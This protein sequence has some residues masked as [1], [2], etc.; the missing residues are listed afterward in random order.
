MGNDGGSIPTRRELVK[1]TDRA[2]TVSE[3]KAT[4]HESL[5]HAWTHCPL[6]TDKL[7]LESAVSDWRGRLYNYE[8][9][10]KNLMAAED[11]EDA[12]EPA[13]EVSFSSTGIKSLRDIV[14]VKFNR[15]TTPGGGGGER[16]GAAWVCPVTLKEFGAGTRAVYI[17]PCGHAFA[18]VAIKK[19]GERRCPEC[20]EAFEE[21]NV[22]PI[23]PTSE[24]DLTRLAARVERLQGEG[25]THGLKKD[26]KGGKKKR[27]RAEENGD[28]EGEDGGKAGKAAKKDERLSGINNARTASLM[29]K[30]L[31]EQDELAKRRKV[32]AAMA[33]K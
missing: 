21:E 5:T 3:L 24:A 19:I 6:S 11:G 15:S 14:K 29:A 22:I 26:K 32:A 2:K 27:K 13:A 1:N 12:S 9:V 28:K 31:A 10:L 18:E 4:A 33:S 16:D 23:L 8:S 20:N 25:L 17:V 7:D 30:V